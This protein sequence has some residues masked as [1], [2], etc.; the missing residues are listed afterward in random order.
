MK[1]NIN[2]KKLNLLGYA[3]CV[4][5]IKSALEELEAMSI[6]LARKFEEVGPKVNENNIHIGMDSRNT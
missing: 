1:I 4:V 5:I 6:E 3:N 2:G